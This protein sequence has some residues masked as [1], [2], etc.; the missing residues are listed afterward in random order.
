MT[1]MAGE[2]EEEEAFLIFFCVCLVAV[3]DGASTIVPIS[4]LTLS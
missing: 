2:E 4:M 1:F 3:P